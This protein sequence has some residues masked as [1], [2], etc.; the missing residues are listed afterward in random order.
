ME[1]EDEVAICPVVD[2]RKGFGFAINT[3]ESIHSLVGNDKPSLR[4]HTLVD[5]IQDVG[6]QFY[7]HA[8][9]QLLQ[10]QSDTRQELRK[11]WHLVQKLKA[12]R[13]LD[14]HACNQ[15]HVE[16]VGMLSTL[17]SD[18]KKEYQSNTSVKT[19]VLKITDLVGAGSTSPTS[20][21]DAAQLEKKMVKRSNS[22][23]GCS[24][25]LRENRCWCILREEKGTL[26]M[27]SYSDGGNME[28]FVKES[29]G[30]VKLSGA[31]SWLWNDQVDMY[32]VGLVYVKMDLV[33]CKGNETADESDSVA[34]V[35]L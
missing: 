27:F 32:D 19:G 24:D 16:L 28:Q 30:K 4:V 11:A 13:H 34:S 17:H 31:M 23:N 1:S 29:N 20:R 12:E 25:G 2:K 15:L 21:V 33:D 22:L 18:E 3:Q 6:E 35:L 10:R 7:V 8:A 9:L 14:K 5:S 26:E